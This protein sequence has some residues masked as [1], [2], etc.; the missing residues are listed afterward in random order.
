MPVRT[1]RTIF[2]FQWR[3]SRN[4]I[5]DNEK[6]GQTN[7]NAEITWTPQTDPTAQGFHA[8]TSLRIKGT[9][10]DIHYT[11]PSN[12]A[13]SFVMLDGLQDGKN[14]IWSIN[15]DRQLSKSMQISLNYEGRKTG[16]HGI[17]HVGRAQ[18]RA[19]F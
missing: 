14:Y 17:V 19:I 7:W 4:S 8:A 3:N 9:F 18:V 15:L 2:N 5:G 16:D 12:T 6:A 11:G 10:A 1:F 13:V